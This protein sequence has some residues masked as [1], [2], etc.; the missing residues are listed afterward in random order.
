MLSAI[1]L[2]AGVGKRLK[3][4]VPKPLV[5][6]CRK[7]VII[8]SLESFN[9]HPDIDEIIVVTSAQNKAAISRVIKKCSFKKIKLLCLGG[10]R[11]Q[12]S[13]YNGLK[14][15]SQSSNWVLIHDSAR[16][17]VSRKFI[18]K[19]ISAAKKTGS[20]ILGVPVKA[21]IKSAKEGFLVDYTVDRSNLWEIQTP[22]VFKKELIFKAYNR[23]NKVNFTD[24]A[25]LVEK[26]GKKIKI[27]Q[28][29]YENIKITTREDLVFAGAI[30]ERR[31]YAV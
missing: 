20:A 8:Y 5:E 21:T 17:F 27:V 7:P 24:D 19:V 14:A 23:Y 29:S 13:V 10:K 31:A 2:A 16:P 6:I 26:L 4:S 1:I 11:R 22:Q 25:S 28:G 3:T 15:V 9:K 18:T 12:D 30:A